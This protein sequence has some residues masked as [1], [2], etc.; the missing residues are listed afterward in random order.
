M[1]KNE[2]ARRA[3]KGRKVINIRKPAEK[4]TLIFF[5]VAHRVCWYFYVL[6]DEYL[7]YCF[8]P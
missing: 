5:L 6:N 2:L 3:Q 8:D 4:L 1:P 7:L